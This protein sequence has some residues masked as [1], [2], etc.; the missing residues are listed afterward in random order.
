MGLRQSAWQHGEE[1]KEM[2]EELKKT[3]KFLPYDEYTISASSHKLIQKND[4]ITWTAITTDEGLLD[5]KETDLTR[6]LLK[7]N[8]EGERNAQGNITVDIDNGDGSYLV[9]IKTDK[10]R[11]RLNGLE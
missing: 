9:S 6:G 7:M 10:G 11:S 5:L 2:Q 1:I 8:K 3:K 4:K